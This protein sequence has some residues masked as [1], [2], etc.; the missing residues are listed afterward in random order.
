VPN[1]IEIAIVE[2]DEAVRDAI[3]LVLSDCGWLIRAYSTGEE[4]LSD[5]EVNTPDCLVL[6]PHLP[7]LSGAAVAR[8]VAAADIELPIIGLTARPNSD[9]ASAVL[10]AGASAMITKPVTF[11]A[12]VHHIQDALARRA[13]VAKSEYP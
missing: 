4:F 9:M 11:E 5:L 12:L 3:A 6:D 13:Q 1:V 7:G 2:D 10:A 8:I